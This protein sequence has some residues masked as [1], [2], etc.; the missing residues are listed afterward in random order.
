LSVERFRQVNTRTGEVFDDGYVAVLLPKRHNGF[1]RRWFAMS[2]DD[3]LDALMQ[4]RRVD[5]FRVLMAFL[6][7][8][9]YDNLIQTSQTEIGRELKMDRAQ[10]NRAVKR[11]VEAGA[12]LEGPRVGLSCSYRLNPH[13]GWKGSAK[14]HHKALEERMRSLGV[15]LVKGGKCEVSSSGRRRGSR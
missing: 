10:V 3:A 11:L 15:A 7:R 13:F 2:Q 9:D 1:G 5:D 4:L 14:S 12:I 8:L 6:K